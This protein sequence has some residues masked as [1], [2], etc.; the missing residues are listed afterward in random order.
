MSSSESLKDK[1]KINSSVYYKD[2]NDAFVD[3]IMNKYAEKFLLNERVDF[4]KECL[5]VFL[6]D[7]KRKASDED[8]LTGP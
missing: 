4:T 6:S 7:Y 3:C 1:V 2:P 8:K 5:H